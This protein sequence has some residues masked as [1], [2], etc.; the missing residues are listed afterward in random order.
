MRRLAYITQIEKPINTV[1]LHSYTTEHEIE[2]KIVQATH[3]FSMTTREITVVKE[4]AEGGENT[5]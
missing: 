5:L 1:K 3:T 4:Y 2:G